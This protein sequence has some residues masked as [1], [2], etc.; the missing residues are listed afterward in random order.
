MA[1]PQG[2]HIWYELLTS[3]RDA[4]VKFYEDVIGWTT[5]EFPGGYGGYIVA[6]AGA[7]GA[8]GI[9]T[10]PAP[11]PPVWLG[12]IGVDDVDASAEKIKALGGAVHFGPADI[13]DVGRFALVEDPQGVKFNIMRG[14]NPEDSKAWDRTGL[15]HCCWNELT[16]T[17]QTAALDF[18]SEMFGWRKDGALPMGEQGDYTFLSDGEGMIGAVMNRQGPGQPAMWN[19]YFRVPDLDAALAKV[20]SGGGKVLQEPMEVPGGERVSFCQDPQGAVFGLV[21]PAR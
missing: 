21:E 6:S 19:Y 1:N 11:T 17:D 12:Y 2:T 7:D 3:D 8:A 16:T 5:A 20:R 10:N 4:A 15:G 13:P 9:M 18:Y 14:S